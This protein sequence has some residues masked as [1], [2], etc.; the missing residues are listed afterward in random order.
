MRGLHNFT[1]LEEPQAAFYA[2][3]EAQQGRWRDAINVGESI[4]VCD[5]GGGTTDFSLIEV[6]EEEGNLALRRAAVGEHILLGGDNMDLTLAYS[7][8]AKLAQQGTQLDNWQFRGLSHNCRK[9]KERLLS[10]PTLESEPIVVLGRGS[11]LIGGTIR[12]ELTRTEIETILLAGFFPVGEADEY[13]E[14]KSQVGVRE[15]GLPYA[16]DAAITRHLAEFLG[17]QLVDKQPDSE[18][19]SVYP[20]AVL[21]NGGVMKAP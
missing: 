13:A 9:A 4:L 1:L 14:K 12:S 8:R 21:F 15:M 3:L 10:N 16:A 11:S 7:V 20:A 2:W 5:V 19:N 6:T 18:G 17:K